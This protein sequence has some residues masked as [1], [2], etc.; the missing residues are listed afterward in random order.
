MLYP[1]GNVM[2]GLTHSLDDLFYF[3]GIFLP[4]RDFDTTIDVYGLR[5][6]GLYG[7]PYI[8]LI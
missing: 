5:S 4:A 3:N 7:L 6:D 2:I 8:L 1:T